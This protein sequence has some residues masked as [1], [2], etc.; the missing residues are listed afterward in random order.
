MYLIEPYN[1]YQKPPKKK[2]WMEVAEEEALLR[3]M[4]LEE[5]QYLKNQ[6]EQNEKLHQKAIDDFILAEQQALK[7]N[8]NLALPQYEPQPSAQQVQDGQFA[9]P[10]GG[11]PGYEGY[12]ASEA[13]EQA[14]FSLS[15]ASGVAPLTVTFVNQTPTPSN[16]TFLWDFGSGSLTSTDITPSALTYTQTGSYTVT[17]QATSAIGAMSIATQTITVSDPTIFAWYTPPQSRTGVAPYSAS[18]QINNTGTAPVSTITGVFDFGDGSPTVPYTASGMAL[19]HVYD[20]GSF[21]ASFSVTESYYGHV[22][23]VKLYISASAPSL[24]P[25]FSASPTTDVAYFT[26][27]FTYLGSADVG[28]GVSFTYRYVF[29][30]GDTSTFTN[31]THVYA[32]GSFPVYMTM[33]ESYYGTTATYILPGGITG[34]VPTITPSF[35][36][37]FDPVTFTAP[38]TASFNNY[39]T[40]DAVGGYTEL[41]YF[42]DLG[43]GSVTSSAITPD[44]FYYLDAGGYTASLQATE[45][46]YPSI[47][48]SVSVTWSLA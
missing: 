15:P 13:T 9:A 23:F 6:T 43:S 19:N 22:S 34:S 28:S 35:T 46:H 10:A 20:T 18:F 40:T 21:T 31:P 11:G 5:Q 3:R 47:T 1:A 4:A 48:A 26:A 12:W 41:I 38:A 42:W 37:I 7:N 29:G 14:A 32:T 30:D 24:N 8:Q 33:T 44:N 25:S 36:I 39:T 2:H 27:S 17:L 16:D 45:S